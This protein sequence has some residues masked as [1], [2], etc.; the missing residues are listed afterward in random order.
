MRNISLT[1]QLFCLALSNFQIFGRLLRL[2][3]SIPHLGIQAISGQQLMVCPFLDNRS[4]FQDQ[5]LISV[6][7]CR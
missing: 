2:R 1:H 7:D 4:I 3:L 6:C 5:D